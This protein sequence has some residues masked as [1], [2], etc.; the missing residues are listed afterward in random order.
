MKKIIL[1]LAGMLT[2]PLI[3]AILVLLM[4]PAKMRALDM[5]APTASLTNA[6]IG[7][8]SPETNLELAYAD[9]GAGVSEVSIE[10][11]QGETIKEIY[12]EKFSPSKQ[13]SVLNL[14]IKRGAPELRQGQATIKVTVIDASLLNNKLVLEHPV[15]VDYIAPQI[16]P[17]SSH[18]N[19]RVGGA[20]LVAYRVSG[21]DVAS[22]GVLVGERRYLGVPGH[23]LSPKITETPGLFVS[24]FPIPTSV[25][26]DVSISLFAHDKVGNEARSS[27]YYT[28][29]PTRFR[30]A[31]LSL[32]R[33]FFEGTIKKLLG[34]YLDF[35]HLPFREY[36]EKVATD[37]QLASD[38]KLINEDYRRG[39]NEKLRS[40]NANSTTTRLF[41]GAFT[42]PL[43]AA[44]T[45]SFGEQRSYSLNSIPAGQSIHLGIDL[46]HLINA[47]VFASNNGKVLFVGDLGIYG[48]TVVIDHG[49]GLTSLYGHL[50]STSVNEQDTVSQ[51]A[52]IGRTGITGLAGGDHLHFEIRLHNESISPFEWLDSHWIKDHIEL[53]IQDIVS[54]IAPPTDTKSALVAPTVE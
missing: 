54:T 13:D 10:I 5:T 38:F 25:D 46:A 39:L 45:S 16:E 20:L 40:I 29:K 9:T 2:V 12:S 8:K 21:D 3:G 44:P 47:P 14:P 6:P 36:D 27:F 42:R 26:E 18:H 19:G 15:I 30:A 22:S 43:S 17:I 32:S 41:E 50:S 34:K 37:E 23:N 1:I 11:S 7:L 51:G 35:A 53:P 33:S 28:V 48:T 4:H 24:L 49:M 52:P 31:D